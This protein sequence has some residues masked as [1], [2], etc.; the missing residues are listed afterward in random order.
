M[1]SLNKSAEKSTLVGERTL[2]NQ[3]CSPHR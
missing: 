2:V 3:L 1:N